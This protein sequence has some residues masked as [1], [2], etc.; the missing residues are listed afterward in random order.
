VPV[1]SYGP[2]KKNKTT[3]DERRSRQINQTNRECTRMN[4]N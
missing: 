3:A 1:I 2:E 4:A